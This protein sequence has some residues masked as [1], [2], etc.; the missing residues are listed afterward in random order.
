[1]IT[2]AAAAVTTTKVTTKRNEMLLT[3][4]WNQD[5]MGWTD[6]GQPTIRPSNDVD[7]VL[8]GKGMAPFGYCKYLTASVRVEVAGD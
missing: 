5:E 2:V 7:I 3:I 6:D 8:N 1:M 4:E